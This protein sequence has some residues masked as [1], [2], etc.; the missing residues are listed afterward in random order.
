MLGDMLIVWLNPHVSFATAMHSDSP[1]CLP[2]LGS[3]GPLCF[4][5]PS[6]NFRR[7]SLLGTVRGLLRSVLAAVWYHVFSMVEKQD[8]PPTR[9]V[10]H[11]DKAPLCPLLSVYRAT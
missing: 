9:S 6:S 8:P 1:A 7:V 2:F 11:R 10:S 4:F 3:V 5:Q